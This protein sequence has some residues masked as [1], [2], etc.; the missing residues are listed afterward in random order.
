[1]RKSLKLKGR[2]QSKNDQL[3]FTGIMH[4]GTTEFKLR[5]DDP[6]QVELNEG[7]S[8]TQD[9]VDGWLMVEQEGQQDHRCYLTLPFP[10][11]NFGR[12]VV[13]K[14]V[15]LMSRSASLM[16]FNPKKTTQKAEDS[17][18]PTAI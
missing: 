3:F 12:Q 9:T 6:H 18:P 14:D 17:L 5:V 15:Q 1:M 4:D 13:V 7:F 2:I 11:E 8:E 16:S 10:A